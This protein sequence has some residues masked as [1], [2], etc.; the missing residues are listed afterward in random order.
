MISRR[1][2]YEVVSL[3]DA[4]SLMFNHLIKIRNGIEAIEVLEEKI[5][6]LVSAYGT[7]CIDPDRMPSL[8]FR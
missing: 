2:S 3:S 4:K 7:W 5:A 1:K 6:S 8:I